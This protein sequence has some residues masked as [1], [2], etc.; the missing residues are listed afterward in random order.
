NTGS[1]WMLVMSGRT[2]SVPLEEAQ[3]LRLD[4]DGQI[5]EITVFGC[6]LPALTTV[7]ATLGR[8]VEFPS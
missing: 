1:D 3:L 5:R 2:G 4:D 8:P 7:M 6:P